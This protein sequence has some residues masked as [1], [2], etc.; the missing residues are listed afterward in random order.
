[1]AWPF[2]IACLITLQPPLIG[3]NLN[4]RD[5]LSHL[6]IKGENSMVFTFRVFPPSA[7][8]GGG[9]LI[10]GPSLIW[11][12]LGVAMEKFISQIPPSE[13]HQLSVVLQLVY[14]LDAHENR[15]S[16][17]GKEPVIIYPEEDTLWNA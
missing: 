9:H 17:F 4:F 11:F 3:N 5:L 12:R 6:H 8:M 10:K 15:A 1:M 7:I 16:F 13:R 14:S 2:G